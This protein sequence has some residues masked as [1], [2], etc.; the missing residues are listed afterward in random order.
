[1][2]AAVKIR[3]KL[4]G[5]VTLVKALFSH[6]METGN[7]KDKETGEKIP[8][9]YI[10]EVDC[11]HNGETVCTAFL[12]ASVSKN[13]YLSFELMGGNQGDDVKLSW[14]DNKGESGSGEAKIK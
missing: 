1:M 2:A 12:G 11:Q 13:P 3:A 5:D 9:H 8:A 7:R 14:V 10:T 4:N 6:P